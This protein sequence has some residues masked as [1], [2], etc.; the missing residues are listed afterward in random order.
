MSATVRTSFSATHISSGVG[1]IHGRYVPGSYSV[2][3]STL[4]SVTSLRHDGARLSWVSVNQVYESGVGSAEGA[5][6]SLSTTG[7]MAGGSPLKRASRSLLN[8][9]WKP[10]VKTAPPSER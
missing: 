2:N 4:R 10:A 8:C 3:I 1:L 6:G 7:T 9:A 5:S